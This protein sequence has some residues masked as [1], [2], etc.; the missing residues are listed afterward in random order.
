GLALIPST[1]WTQVDPASKLA[2]KRPAHAVAQAAS[3]QTR[4]P[5]AAYTFTLLSFPGSLDTVAI[6]LNPGA[7]TSKIE[8]V[9]EYSA[10]AFLAHVSGT[11]IVA[12]T[13]EAENYPDDATPSDINDL[14]Q[15]VGTY[16]D[17]SG[18][19]HGFELSSG[20]V[21][22]IDVP[23]AG[24][25]GTYPEAINNSGQIVGSWSDGGVLQGFTLIGGT[26]TS[27]NYPGATVTFGQ[28]INNAGEIVG[29][30]ISP[31]SNGDQGYLLS[32]GTYTS[33]E[34]PGAVNTEAI[35]LNDAG[36]IVGYYYPNESNLAEGFVL[37]GGVFTTVTIPGEPYT[38]LYDINDS[39][40]LLGNYQD[41]AGL[42]VGFLA[43]P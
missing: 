27:F 8:I 13:Y 41:A 36:V 33:I 15:I 12:E 10:G 38:V 11:K 42:E 21:T 19:V 14:G 26:Y 5:G 2:G 35:A 23:F 32:G 18:L 39:G 6:G 43:T 3:R 31:D 37:S 4:T 20:K 28:D 16:V 1:S 29:I 7:S 25:I 17:S 22:T 24:A 9:G 40:M 30:Y 34:V